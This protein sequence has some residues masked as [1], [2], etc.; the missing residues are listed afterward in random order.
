MQTAKNVM[1]ECFNR[2]SIP[3]AG[4]MDSRLKTA[5]MTAI[6]QAAKSLQLFKFSKVAVAA[7]PR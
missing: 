2:A 5:G 4:Q 6:F 1:P 7:R 3:S